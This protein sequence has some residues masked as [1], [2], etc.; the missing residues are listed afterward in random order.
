[1][2]TIES[3]LITIGNNVSTIRKYRA[4]SKAEL[5]KNIQYDR[6]DLLQLETGQQDFYISTLVKIAESMDISLISIF[7][8]DFD[9]AKADPFVIDDFMGIY[10]ENI[11]NQ[12]KKRHLTEYGLA[13]KAEIDQTTLSRILK[14]KIKNPRISTMYY[15]ANNLDTSVEEL[16]TRTSKGG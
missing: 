15:I 7:S 14:G 6:Q 4:L 13:L 8:R 5:A 16:L 2:G 10:C 9:A 12:I 11:R 1:M 3:L